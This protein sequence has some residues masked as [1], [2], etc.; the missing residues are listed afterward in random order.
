MT[1]NRAYDI[2]ETRSASLPRQIIG[3]WLLYL[4]WGTNPMASF[5]PRCERDAYVTYLKTDEGRNYWCVNS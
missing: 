3:D 5:L 4:N 2:L 1:L